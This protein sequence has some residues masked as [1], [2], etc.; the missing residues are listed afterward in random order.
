MKVLVIED[1]AKILS[2]VR[3]GLQE[4]GFTVETSSDGDEGYAL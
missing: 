2:F 4:R 3:K 1:D